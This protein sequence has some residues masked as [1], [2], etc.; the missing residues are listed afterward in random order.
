MSVYSHLINKQFVH[1]SAL[2]WLWSTHKNCGAP[3]KSGFKLPD[4]ELFPS[5]LKISLAGSFARVET[6]KFKKRVHNNSLSTDLSFEMLAK[7][8]W[9]EWWFSNDDSVSKKVKIFQE[10]ISILNFFTLK[11]EIKPRTQLLPLKEQHNLLTVMKWKWQKGGI[12]YIRSRQMPFI[13]SYSEH[14]CWCQQK[15]NSL[16]QPFCSD[17]QPL[18][19]SFPDCSKPS[20]SLV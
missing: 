15:L 16:N 20:S 11:N 10:S 6:S 1:S 5:I 18:F 8:H 13:C 2:L 3:S 14:H 12:S 19:S 7:F 9:Y 17:R 4:M